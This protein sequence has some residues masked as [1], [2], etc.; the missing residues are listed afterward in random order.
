MA[1]TTPE[2]RFCKEPIL[3]IETHC[4][5]CGKPVDISTQLRVAIDTTGNLEHI[6]ATIS[7]SAEDTNV[8][9]ATIQLKDRFGG[10]LAR[11]G[12]VFGYISSDANGDALSAAHDGGCAIG[13]DGLMIETLANQAFWLVSEADGDID[14]EFTDS[15]DFT[16]YLVL[17]MPDGRLVISDVM[18]HAA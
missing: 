15:G 5:S 4:A 6:T 7:V 12:V 2:C 3:V 17:V 1:D 9:T 8:V 16:A 18:T 11:R 13:T 14:I 10:D